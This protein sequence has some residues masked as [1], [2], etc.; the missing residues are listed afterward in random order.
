VV[1]VSEQEYIQNVPPKPPD[2]NTTM[3]PP[4]PPDPALEIIS[5]PH[6]NLA[7]TESIRTLNGPS[8]PTVSALLKQQCL[9]NDWIFS[10]H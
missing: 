1:N 6:L 7:T 5:E 10:T 4:D 9:I 8:D 2:P 3:K